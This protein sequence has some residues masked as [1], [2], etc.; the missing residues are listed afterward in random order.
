MIGLQKRV[1]ETARRIHQRLH[2]VFDDAQFRGLAPG[3]PAASIA[4]RLREVGKKRER[5]HFSALHYREVPAFAQRLRAMAGVAPRCLEFTL[6]TAART[7]EAI[8][9]AWSELDLAAGVWTVPA[10]RMKGGEE[11][12]VHLSDRAVEILAEQRGLHA[13]WVFPSPGGGDKPMSNGGMLALLRRIGVH[14]RTTVHGLRASF[15]TWAAEAFGARPD[16]VEA[17]LAHR[18]RDRVR[19]AYSRATFTDERRKLLIAW[20]TYCNGA[21]E[22][23]NIFELR[24]RWRDAGGRNCEA[25]VRL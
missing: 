18:E 5:G 15:S 4:R 20:A 10:G 11:H 22:Q 16:V 7:A 24:G 17:S 8:G 23:N 14:D 9:L 1:P 19:A 25:S 13:R 3:N 12:I 2:V 6:L 21:H